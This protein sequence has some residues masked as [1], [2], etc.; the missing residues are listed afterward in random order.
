M[1][2]RSLCT[3]LGEG[4]GEKDTLK[5]PVAVRKAVLPRLHCNLGAVQATMERSDWYLVPAS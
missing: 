4:V 1:A 3:G 2:R 5:A